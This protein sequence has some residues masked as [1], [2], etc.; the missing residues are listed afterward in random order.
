MKKILLALSALSFAA[1]AYADNIAK[2]ELVLLEEIKDESGQGGAQVASYRDA[3]DFLADVY[4]GNEVSRK[5]DQFDIRAVMCTRNDV[6]ASKADFKI[7]ATG[8]PFVLSQNFDTPDSDL[9]TYYFKDGKF[10]Y[11]HKGPGMSDESSAD[12][13]ARLAAF[14]KKDHDLA[15][16]EAAMKAKANDK[17]TAD[18][19]AE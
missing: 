4:S 13:K 7:L 10:R 12:L 17:K 19:D 8:I 11:I 16:K 2:C 18:K 5:I 15:E 3:S 9:I 6:I 14:N 1:P